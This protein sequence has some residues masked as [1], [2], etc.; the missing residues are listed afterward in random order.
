MPKSLCRR[1]LQRTGIPTAVD[2]PDPAG[3]APGAGRPGAPPQVP[4]PAPA[5]HGTRSPGPPQ[6]S[7]ANWWGARGAGLQTTGLFSPSSGTQE[8]DRRVRRAIPPPSL[9][10]RVLPCLR[11]F[12]S[13][14]SLACGG[15]SPVFASM[16]PSSLCL[17]VLSSSYKDGSYWT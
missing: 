4:A 14:P 7:A 5:P 11:Q 12:R 16:W 17:C 13:W 9:Y 2:V 10:R 15:I 6:P 1:L 8:S 3:S